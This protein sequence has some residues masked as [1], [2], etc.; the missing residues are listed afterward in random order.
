MGAEVSVAMCT[1]QGEAYVLQQLR[2][3]ALQTRPPDELV[4]GDDCSTD[5]TVALV[6]QFAQEA[7]FRVSLT[8]NEQRLGVARNFEKCIELCDGEFIFCADQ[9][10]V[11][12]PQKLQKLVERLESVPSAGLVF[13]DAQIVNE[14]LEPTGRTLW[15]SLGFTA[16]T[17]RDF[18][19]GGALAY[20]L[21]EGIAAGMTMGFRSGFKNLVLPVPAGWGH[22]HFIPLLIASVSEAAVVRECLVKW[23]QHTAQQTGVGRMRLHHRVRAAASR[24]AADQSQKVQLWESAHQRLLD[25]REQYGVAPQVL[26]QFAG[27]VRHLRAR[28]QIQRG[29]RS[30]RLLRHEV[31]SG[32]YFRYSRGWWSVASDVLPRI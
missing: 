6:R 5:R 31:S 15:E 19:D 30:W 12:H 28:S 8:V 7:A 21:R 14:D 10:D 16:D 11:W 17:Q 1:H 24:D 2:S 27:K 9:D 26:D 29:V 3:I 4:I 18:L 25:N 23:R 20:M 32:N 13:C 22:D